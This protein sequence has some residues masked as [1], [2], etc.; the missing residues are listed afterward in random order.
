[1]SP[2]IY[3][4]I[5][6]GRSYRYYFIKFITR[7]YSPRYILCSSTLPLRIKNRSSIRHLRRV[8]SLIPPIY[9]IN[10]SQTMNKST[11][12]HNIYW[13]KLNI[14]PSTLPR[15]KRNTTTI[16]RLPWRLYK[17]KRNFIYRVITI[18]YSINTIYLHLMRSLCL[19]TK[20]S[21]KTTHTYSYRMKWR[22]TSR[23][24]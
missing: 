18:I 24:P 9:R 19:T 10:P 5:H 13:G 20:S 12:F 15:I 1:M 6:N 8:Y 2:R 22:S 11:I 17:M 3:L 4:S 21:S 23:L 7:Y 14:F 16:F